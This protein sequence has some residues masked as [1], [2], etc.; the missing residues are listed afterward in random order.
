MQFQEAAGGGQPVCM[1]ACG[2]DADYLKAVK[3]AVESRILWNSKVWHA[4][5]SAPSCNKNVAF[6]FF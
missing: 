5:G 4:V 2:K 1:L 3:I 6:I